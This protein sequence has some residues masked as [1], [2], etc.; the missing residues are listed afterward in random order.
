MAEEAARQPYLEHPGGREP[1]QW[2]SAGATGRWLGTNPSAGAATSQ[3]CYFKC[4]RMARKE[5]WLRNERNQHVYAR[6][7]AGPML[8]W[9]FGSSPSLPAAL[10]V[11][12]MSVNDT[13]VGLCI[14][15]HRLPTSHCLHSL[16]LLG[17]EDFQNSLTDFRFFFLFPPPFAVSISLSL[18]R[19][20]LSKRGVVSL[21]HSNAPQ[22]LD[23]R[24]IIDVAFNFSCSIRTPQ[25]LGFKQRIMFC[26]PKTKKCHFFPTEEWPSSPGSTSRVLP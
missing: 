11:I 1:P 9:P 22:L 19:K 5:G 3:P 6:K 8:E 18:V 20:T 26:N 25:S 4:T 21:S 10:P 14:F 13:R 2:L 15:K 24:R 7:P 16:G 23:Q 17:V 12:Y